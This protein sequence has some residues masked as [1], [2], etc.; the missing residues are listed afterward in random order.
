MKIDL[1]DALL[2]TGVTVAQPLI[3]DNFFRFS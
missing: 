3:P 1:I 2:V